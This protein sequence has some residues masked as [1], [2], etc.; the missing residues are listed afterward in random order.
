MTG[1]ASPGSKDRVIEEGWRKQVTKVIAHVD[2]DAFY[3]QVR[4]L[5]L[6]SDRAAWSHI[7]PERSNKTMLS[8]DYLP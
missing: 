7:F 5:V 1:P 8:T 2:L 3:T 4:L 6:I